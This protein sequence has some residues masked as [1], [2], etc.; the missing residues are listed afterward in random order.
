MPQIVRV[1]ATECER[2]FARMALMSLRHLETIAIRA[3]DD[4]SERGRMQVRNSCS[5]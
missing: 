5:V 2:E 3:N 4:I 1:E